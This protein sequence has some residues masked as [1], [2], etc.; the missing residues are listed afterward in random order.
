MHSF[1]LGYFVVFLFEKQFFLFFFFT[2]DLFLIFFLLLEEKVLLSVGFAQQFGF[3][4][5]GFFVGKAIGELF[6]YLLELELDFFK[7]AGV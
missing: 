5:G 1:Y 7:E 3:G 6:V 2:D 4:S